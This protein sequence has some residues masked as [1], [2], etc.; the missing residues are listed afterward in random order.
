MWDPLELRLQAV[1]LGMPTPILFKSIRCSQPLSHL[2]SA[3]QV[4]TEKDSSASQEFYFQVGRY[5]YR[6]QKYPRPRREKETAMVR[7]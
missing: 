5:R 3:E 6:S 7:S 4:F 1:V 2:S